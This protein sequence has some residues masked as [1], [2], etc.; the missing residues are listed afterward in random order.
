M[1]SMLQKSGIDE[2]SSGHKSRTHFSFWVYICGFENKE[3]SEKRMRTMGLTETKKVTNGEEQS[4]CLNYGD[5][6]HI[7][8][9][10]GY[11]IP[12]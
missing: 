10:L 5:P 1:I 12:S 11:E 4:L 2:V 7:S 3:S 6:R 9:T 8:A